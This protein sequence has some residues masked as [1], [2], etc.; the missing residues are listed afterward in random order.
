[1]M[2]GREEKTSESD[3]IRVDFL[4]QEET[5]QPGRLGMTFA[6]GKK[7]EGADG[8][9][10]R[11]LAADL[12]RLVEEYR[13]EVLVS[14]MEHTEHSYLKV[15]NL[16]QEAGE[17]GMEVLHLPIPD[18]R[19]PADSEADRYVPL[20]EDMAERLEKGQT[21]VVHCRGGQG[22][23]GM[24]A[25][26]VL[27]ALGHPAVKALEIVRKTRKGAVETPEQEDRVQFLQM[28]L[29][30]RRGSREER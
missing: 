24:F 15:P 17:R 30:S 27:V 13:V 21:V 9:W 18:G 20:V 25:A 10:D 5:G 23:S 3:P 22:R 7:S 26:S 14:L 8:V 16:L 4:S 12:K 6:P 11:D 28:E 29:G 19:A 1:M 2:S